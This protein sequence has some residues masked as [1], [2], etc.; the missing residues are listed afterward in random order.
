MVPRYTKELF[1]ESRKTKTKVILK[2]DQNKSKYEKGLEGNK[3]LHLDEPIL[4]QNCAANVSNFINFFPQPLTNFM[5]NHAN[6]ITAP[7][8]GNLLSSSNSSHHGIAAVKWNNTNVRRRDDVKEPRC[9]CIGNLAYSVDV[10]TITASLPS[11]KKETDVVTMS[12]SSNEPQARNFTHPVS[13][14]LIYD[15]AGMRCNKS[16]STP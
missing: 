6:L 11:S 15:T 13:H 14:G 2:S 4:C 8:N 12:C 1:S 9:R 7:P 16:K 5:N 3:V 10:K